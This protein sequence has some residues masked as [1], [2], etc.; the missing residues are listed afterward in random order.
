MVVSPY[1]GAVG[2][3]KTLILFYYVPANSS[4]RARPVETMEICHRKS[5]SCFLRSERT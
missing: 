1:D 2:G 4:R 3:C 5:I